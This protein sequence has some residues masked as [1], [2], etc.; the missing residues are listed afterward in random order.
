M[1]RLERNSRMRYEAET[2]TFVDVTNAL[3]HARLSAT[4]RIVPMVLRN[5]D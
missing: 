5:L 2:E 4:V 1:S 3:S